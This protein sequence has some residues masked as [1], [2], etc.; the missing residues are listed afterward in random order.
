MP[1][2]RNSCSNALSTAEAYSSKSEGCHTRTSFAH[3]AIFND[4]AQWIE[5]LDSGAGD[6]NSRAE[7]AA[8]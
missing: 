5:H 1:R 4:V 8:Q 3:R 7:E 2:R 6:S